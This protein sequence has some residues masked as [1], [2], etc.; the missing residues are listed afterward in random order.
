MFKKQENLF[1]PGLKQK[2]NTC[3]RSISNTNKARRISISRA[4]D[5]KFSS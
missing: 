2:K 3:T 1:G 4:L 5:F